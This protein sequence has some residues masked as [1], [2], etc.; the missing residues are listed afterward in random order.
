VSCTEDVLEVMERGQRNRAVAETR[1]NNRSSRSHQVGWAQEPIG[2]ALA[3]P[4]CR[5]H[6]QL[7]GLQPRH[8]SKQA[9]RQAVAACLTGMCLC[10]LTFH[11]S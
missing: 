1:M 7:W 11:C 6:S 5:L 9:G 4:R 2:C 10:A 8:A 3:G